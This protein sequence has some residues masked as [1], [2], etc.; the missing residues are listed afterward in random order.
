MV[1]LT[2]A[3]TSTHS[4]GSAISELLEL[5]HAE[6]DWEAKQAGLRTGAQLETS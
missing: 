5:V 1:H 6:R 2:V 3:K 4:F